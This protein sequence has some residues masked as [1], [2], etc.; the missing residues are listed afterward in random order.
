MEIGAKGLTDLVAL[1]NTPRPIRQV[2]K[3]VSQGSRD[4]QEA[5]GKRKG[6]I[7]LAILVGGPSPSK[8]YSIFLLSSLFFTFLGSIFYCN[9]GEILDSLQFSIRAISSYVNGEHQNGTGVEML[10]KKG[11]MMER[12]R[13][14]KLDLSEMM[15]FMAETRGPLLWG[16]EE[17][18]N[19]GAVFS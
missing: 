3:D 6:G 15:E 8:Q 13:N 16:R 12:S 14:I 19:H 17:K 10:V 9:S 5:A 4:K 2:L 1:G 7:G 18:N 11:S